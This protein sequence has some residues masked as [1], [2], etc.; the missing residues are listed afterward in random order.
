M[1]Q[2]ADEADGVRDDHVAGLRQPDAPRGGV[3]RGEQL[4]G[5]VGAAFVSALN[6]VD[7]PALV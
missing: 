6:S 4:V 3:E 7:L 2:V 1:R 5:L